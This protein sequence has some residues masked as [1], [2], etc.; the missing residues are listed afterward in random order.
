MHYKYFSISKKEY[1][2]VVDKFV[3]RDLFEKKN[4]KWIRKFEIF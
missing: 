1:T 3:N 2:E 4:N